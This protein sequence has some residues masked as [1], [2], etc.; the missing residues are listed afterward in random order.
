MR[1]K[2]TT[3]VPNEL[4]DL[5]LKRLTFSELKLIL[6]IIRQTYGWKLRNGKRKKRDRI[7]YNLFQKKTGLSKRVISD[8]IQS[9]IIK[10]LISVTDYDGNKLHTPEERKGKVCIYYAPLFSPNAEMTKKVC[11]NVHQPMQHKAYNKTK[12]TKLIV[13]KTDIPVKRISDWERMQQIIESK[14]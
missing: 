11:R 5:Y 4:F 1:Y 9:L 6:Y 14:R 10:H 12:E 2:K 3:H 13:Q 8:V 7:T